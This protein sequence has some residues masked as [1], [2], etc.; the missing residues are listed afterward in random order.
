MIMKRTDMR[1]DF[2]SLRPHCWR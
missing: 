2:Y 1:R